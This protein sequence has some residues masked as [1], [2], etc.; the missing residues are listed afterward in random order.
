MK[1]EIFIL[2][3][4]IQ[5]GKT[6]LLLNWAKQQHIAG[7]LT[8]VVEGSRYFLDIETGN[9]FPMNASAEETKVLEVGK[10]RF[11]EAG[12][13]QASMLLKDV[14]C[15]PLP[16]FLVIDEIGPL[17]LNQQKGFYNT[18][19]YML[20]NLEMN[21]RIVLIV[22]DKCLTE[23]TRL[24]EQ[25]DCTVTVFTTAAFKEKLSFEKDH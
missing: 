11:S 2:T 15:K 21:R 14:C 6:T 22:R 19:L 23:A 8:P 25:K 17:E 5:S 4:P 7:I 10:Y 16:S 1:R 13:E 24:L 18:L 12:F 20:D 9:H 3:G